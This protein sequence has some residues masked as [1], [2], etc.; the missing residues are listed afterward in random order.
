MMLT[1]ACALP[2]RQQCDI[3]NSYS[4]VGDDQIYMYTISTE[5]TVSV[6]RSRHQGLGC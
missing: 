1:D 6:L 4:K 5:V 2:P 3:Y